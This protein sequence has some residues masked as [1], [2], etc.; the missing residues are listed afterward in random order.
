VQ[1]DKKETFQ[2]ILVRFTELPPDLTLEESVEKNYDLCDYEFMN[3][4]KSEIDA[5]MVEGADIEAQQYRDILDQINK[6]MAK[7][8]GGAQERLQKILEKRALPAMESEIV[9]MARKGEI[10]EALVLLIEANVQQAEAAGAVQAVEVL[11]KL[12]RR[13]NEEQDRK[14]PDDQRLM[15]ALMRI[16]SSE[17]RRGLL[18]EA[19]KPSKTMLQE[20]GFA[21]GPPLISPPVFINA[22]R[23]FIMNFGNVDS[24]NL[25]GRAQ[26]I[27]DDAQAV[28]TELYGEGMT[29]K[30]QQKLMWEKKTV[31]VWDLANFEDQAVMSGEEVPWRNDK[32]DNMAP[33]DAL[34]ERVRR[35]GGGDGGDAPI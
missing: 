11:R 32:Y 30:Q 26:E 5:C 9:K 27:I 8:I 19:F 17:E 1:K 25:M 10:D 7:R 6:T 13:I 35:I 4:L 14:L 34:G 2:N 16:S 33:E 21:E 29:P 31:S 18:Y 28:A 22:V 15:R 3:M 23:Q 12:I 24:F 20:G